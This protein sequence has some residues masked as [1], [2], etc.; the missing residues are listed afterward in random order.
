VIFYGFVAKNAPTSPRDPCA[1]FDM[2]TP[3]I[4]G[5]PAIHNLRDGC[6]CMNLSLT[7]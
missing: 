6:R 5:F 3:P 7:H 2:K 4:T 1:D